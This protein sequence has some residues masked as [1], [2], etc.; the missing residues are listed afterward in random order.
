MQFLHYINKIMGCPEI[1]EK[2]EAARCLISFVH[3]P[4]VMD[5][6]CDAAVTTTSQKFRGVIL[7]VLKSRAEE[8]CKRF[9]DAVL[10]SKSSA[11]RRWALVNLSLM[12]CRDAQNAV[13]SGLYDPDASVRE[14]AVRNIDL[15]ADK[16]VR[17]VFDHYFKTHDEDKRACDPEHM[18]I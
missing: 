12:G 7:E 2:I 4:L 16:G 14:A 1:N 18:A 3:E 15:Y 5:V 11:V 17:K 13:I 10:W 9:S 8:A 6:L